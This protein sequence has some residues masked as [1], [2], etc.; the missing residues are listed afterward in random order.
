M[1][2][3]PDEGLHPDDLANREPIGLRRPAVDLDRHVV[4]VV[5]SQAV[6]HRANEQRRKQAVADLPEIIE[7]W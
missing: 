2:V 1:N 5:H 4:A 3:S 7:Q 6:V